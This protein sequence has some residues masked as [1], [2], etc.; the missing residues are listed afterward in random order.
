MGRFGGTSLPLGIREFVNQDNT[1]KV[2]T[3]ARKN[4]FDKDEIVVYH[5]TIVRIEVRER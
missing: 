2:V 4:K 3:M 5:I 1:F